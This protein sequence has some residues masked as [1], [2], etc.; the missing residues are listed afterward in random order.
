MFIDSSLNYEILD[1]VSTEVFQA[2]WIEIFLAQ[3]KHVI[4][5]IIY[6]QQNS[7]D[8]FLKYF[9]ET[10]EKFISS[11]K[12]LCIMGDF[13]LDLLKIENSRFSRD[14]FLLL[15][16]CYLAPS[17]DKPTHV[18]NNSATLRDNI[19]INTAERLIASGNII[20]DITN[21]LSQFCVMKL[22]KEKMQIVLKPAIHDF[23]DFQPQASMMICLLWTGMN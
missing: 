12:S 3:R 23:L 13:N 19:F 14:F 11:G 15:Q 5:G 18:Y 22:T 10:V 21:H 4:F 16:S 6:R 7:P 1:K 2:L 9:D 17:I 8:L 20:S